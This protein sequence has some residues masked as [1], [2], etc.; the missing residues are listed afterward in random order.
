MRGKIFLIFGIIFLVGLISADLISVNSGGSEDII[1]NPNSYIEGF[2]TDFNLRPIMQ[3]VFLSSFSGENLTVDNLSVSYESFDSDF[4]YITNISDWRLNGDSIAVVNYPFDT[5]RIKGEIRDYS[6][7]ENNGSLGGGVLSRIPK[8]QENCQIGGCYEFD[9]EDDVIVAPHQGGEGITVSMW[10]KRND[11]VT[12]RATRKG[13]GTG[14]GQFIMRFYSD[15]FGVYLGGGSPA[16]GYHMTSGGGITLGNW[17][18][19]L[20][21][22]EG[23]SLKMYVDGELITEVLVSRS[24]FFDNEDIR[25][26]E[27]YGSMDEDFNGSI[28]EF[29]VYNRVLSDEQIRVLYESELNQNPVEK[30]V[31]SMTS[32]GET[33]QVAM[34]SNDGRLDSLTVLSNELTIEDNSPE[35][36]EPVLVSV[37]F[38]NESDSDLECFALI[39]DIDSDFLNISVEWVKNG[40]VELSED[41]NN[42]YSNGSSFSATLDSSYLTLGDVWMC[43]VRL[44]DGESFSGWG[45]SNELEIIDITPPN[46]TIISPEPINYTDLNVS[47]NIS[48]YDNENVSMCFYDLD[49]LGNESMI[50]INDSY[51][52]YL[53]EN[54]GPGYHDLWYYCNDTSGNWGSNYT[55]FTI[56]DEAAIAILLSEDLLWGIRWDVNNLPIDDFDAIGNNFEGPTDYYL[57]I[58]A[59]NT[60]V[61]LY[62]RADGDLF[63]LG[64]DSIGLGNETFTVS[65]TDRNVTIGSLYNMS[66]SYVLIGQDLPSTEVYMKFYLDA[67]ASQAAGNYINNLD[68]RAVR[69][70]RGI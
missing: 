11:L 18:H 17:H 48:V 38:T 52:W 51:F 55:N 59:T 68:F 45:D 70:G 65:T 5:N 15:E 43:S 33:W 53:D 13:G 32:K 31:Y 34:T 29:K 64:G 19:V 40:A 27:H 67:P 20:W 61:D 1:L 28:D 44:T 12:R 23:S 47:F 54:L 21:T 56:E 24:S 9:G 35:T 58:S 60:L 46:V 36:P 14:G 41:Y 22:Y 69:S 49:G 7:Y 42:S 10:I 4:D 25:I 6:I 39:E 63:N 8:W 30:M 2:F 3:N 26:G 57:N 16:P 50:E 62:V 66:T 37:D